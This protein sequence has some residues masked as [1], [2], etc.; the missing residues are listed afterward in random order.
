MKLNIHLEKDLAGQCDQ[1][2]F[3]DE[4][5]LT[6]DKPI[7]GKE[8]LPCVMIIDTENVYIYDGENMNCIFALDD[9]HSIDDVRIIKEK[10]IQEVVKM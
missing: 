5:D 7:E 10:I 8:L 3:V 6:Q 9:L 2:M 1:Y 4:I